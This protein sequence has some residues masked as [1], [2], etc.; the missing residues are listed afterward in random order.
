[1]FSFWT[2]GL[3]RSFLC[4][5][6]RLLIFPWSWINLCY[7]QCR[8]KH[9]Y[10]C[11]VF[12]ATG[13]CPQQSRCKLH[14]PKKTIKSSKRSKPD[15]PQ[16]SS[17]GR[18]FDT[19]ARLGSETTKV[20]LGQDDRQ[21]Q[22]RVFSGGFVDFITLDTD[23]D[24]GADASDSLQLTELDSGDLDSQADNLDAL[25]KPLRIMRTARVWCNRLTG[26]GIGMGGI[27]R[28]QRA[29]WEFWWTSEAAWDYQFDSW[30]E[31]S[32]RGISKFWTCR[33]ITVCPN[34]GATGEKSKSLWVLWSS[35][36][37]LLIQSFAATLVSG[38][39]QE[40]EGADWVFSSM[41]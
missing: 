36:I 28:F 14:H 13:E 18:Y 16:N 26:H 27:S 2:S 5:E 17:W 21:K 41:S 19:S 33:L 20:S 22:Q 10:V 12:E 25:I 31:E 24:E 15:N 29:N 7:K 35:L 11:P 40:D 9:S 4:S 6:P 34:Q 37:T 38:L 1:M 32:A 39:S 30:W 3:P 23:G 8:K